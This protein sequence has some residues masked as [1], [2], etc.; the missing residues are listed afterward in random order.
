MAQ[1]MLQNQQSYVPCLKLK[2]DEIEILMEI[3]FH[4]DQLFEERARNAQWTFRDGTTKYDKLEGLT[5]EA[6]DWHAKVNLYSVSTLPNNLPIENLNN[7][8]PYSNT[9][10]SKSCSL[11]F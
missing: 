9:N 10:L 7:P 8:S 1:L 2:P 4:G 5:T 6:A 11:N 3:P